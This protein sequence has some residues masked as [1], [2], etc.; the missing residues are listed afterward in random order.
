MHLAH[1]I[2]P[3]TGKPKLPALRRHQCA[4]TKNIRIRLSWNNLP[5]AIC[6]LRPQRQGPKRVLG[7]DGLRSI[8]SGG[9]GLRRITC[10]AVSTKPLARNIARSKPFVRLWASNTQ[11]SNFSTIT[12]VAA[13]PLH[14]WRGLSSFVCSSSLVL[15]LALPSF[16]FRLASFPTFPTL[17][18]IQ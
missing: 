1:L 2:L 15:A 11:M 13:P 18:G 8:R 7:G 14:P 6:R 10:E 3:L 17:D 5:I 12:I 16:S 4:K 9:R